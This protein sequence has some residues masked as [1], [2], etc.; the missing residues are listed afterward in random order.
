MRALER[1]TESGTLTDP[2]DSLHHPHPHPTRRAA[3]A[4][5]GT[6][7]LRALAVLLGAA[8]L[9]A[10]G[11]SPVPTVEIL[12]ATPE[13]LIASDDTNDDLTLKVAY[14]DGD[15]D[16]GQ[17]V[18]H[19]HDC[20]AEGLVTTLT[21]PRIANDEAVA[22]GVPIEGELDLVLAD[23]GAIEAAEVPPACA[24]LGVGAPEGGAQVFCVVLV[25]AAGNESEGACSS[26][27]VV[28]P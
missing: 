10:C 7:A 11:V 6:L 3:R 4:P 28:T 13:A 17:G 20:R 1:G 16:L 18:A 8:S 26:P 25:D 22:Q 19:I 23:L 14:S 24:E 21:I 9:T 27:V 5:T 2:S 15:G 12:E